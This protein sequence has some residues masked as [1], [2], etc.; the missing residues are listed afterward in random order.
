MFA[1]HCFVPC[2]A[3]GEEKKNTP[4]PHIPVCFKDGVEEEKREK[5]KKTEGC[6]RD[7]FMGYLESSYPLEET[8]D[9]EVME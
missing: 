4:H 1:Q 5:E 3:F 6:N 8:E 9:V 7:K 2:L